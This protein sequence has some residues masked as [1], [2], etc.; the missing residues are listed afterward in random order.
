MS[1]DLHE[2]WSELESVPL[3]ETV[4]KVNKLI[5]EQA[6]EIENLR[7][8]IEYKNAGIKNQQAKIEKLRELVDKL[9]RELNA[10]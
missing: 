1:V 4:S 2:V 9:T 7:G 10:D 5:I 6:E 3:T 8:Q